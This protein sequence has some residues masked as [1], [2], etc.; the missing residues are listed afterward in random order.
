MNFLYLDLLLTCLDQLEKFLKH[1]ITSN[2]VL[3]WENSH[4]MVKEGI[5]LGRVVS[6]HGLKV[7]RAKVQII[8]T[9]PPPTSVK[10]RLFFSWTCQLLSKIYQGF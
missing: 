7:N 5:V 4:F 9:L 2:L 1:C 3:S 6:E 10:R 8:S